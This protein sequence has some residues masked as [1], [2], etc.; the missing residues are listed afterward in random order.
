M[1][2]PASH[3]ASV[4]L[5][6]NLASERQHAYCS[7]CTY[8][9]QRPCRSRVK[10]QRNPQA[11]SAE[12]LQ[13]QAPEQ[14]CAHAFD[15]SMGSCKHKMATTSTTRGRR[16]RSSCAR[17]GV[18]VPWRAPGLHSCAHR[19][20]PATGAQQTGRRRPQAVC[21]RTHR[22]AAPVHQRHASALLAPVRV[23]T[24]T[25]PLFPT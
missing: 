16:Q 23:C 8:T 13:K 18:R 1:S 6:K 15:P 9:L 11:Q 24:I 19:C 5:G 14:P 21:A 4:V 7:A 17:A 22:A 10:T 2:D 3:A 12:Q 25:V 20:W